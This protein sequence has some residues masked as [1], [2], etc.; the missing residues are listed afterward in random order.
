MSEQTYKLYAVKL[1]ATNTERLKDF[2]FSLLANS[3]YA[4]VYSDKTLSANFVVIP[5]DTQ[6]TADER[7]WL[8]KTKVMVNA[9]YIEEHKE[10]IL[11]ELDN[12]LTN[13]EKA[14]AEE[15]KKIGE[16]K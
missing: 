2:E 16:K 11:P 1:S 14:L 12:L 9:R 10:E 8:T 7:D 4:L 5:E 15:Q 6:I 3:R 13:L